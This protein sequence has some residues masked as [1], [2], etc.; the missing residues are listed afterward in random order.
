MIYDDKNYEKP[1]FQI[2]PERQ[3]LYEYCESHHIALTVMK[4]F[5]GGDLLDENLSP[6]GVK[7]TPLQ[8]NSLLF[9]KTRSGFCHGGK[10]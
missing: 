10:S 2:A 1:L 5:G 3:H 8:C 6:F 9:D 4:A 7:M